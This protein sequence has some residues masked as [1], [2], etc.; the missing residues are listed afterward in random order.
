MRTWEKILDQDTRL[1]FKLDALKWSVSYIFYT[2]R[3]ECM[4]RIDNYPHKGKQG[5]HIHRHDDKRVEFKE[6]TFKEAETTVINIG[7]RI[8][9]EIKN[10]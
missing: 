5:S 9:E 4:A 6:L 10:G 3:W 1:V 2:G 8:M 7:N